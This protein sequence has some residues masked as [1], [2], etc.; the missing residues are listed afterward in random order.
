MEK[1]WSLKKK[2]A[3]TSCTEGARMTSQLCHNFQGSQAVHGGENIDIP[4]FRARSLHERLWSQ[5]WYSYLLKK[6]WMPNLLLERYPI[7]SLIELYLLASYI[8]ILTAWVSALLQVTG[9][10]TGVLWWHLFLATFLI[11]PH[12]AALVIRFGTRGPNSATRN[13]LNL[14]TLMAL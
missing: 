6:A 7:I 8:Y 4:N 9:L 1:G 3:N 10:H 11:W 13:T 12:S 14:L 2:L 5:S